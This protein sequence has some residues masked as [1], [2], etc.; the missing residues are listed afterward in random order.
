MRMRMHMQWVAGLH[1]ERIA[2]AA[3]LV[4]IEL[5][6]DV[7]T[8]RASHGAEPATAHDAVSSFEA[9]AIAFADVPEAHA[10]HL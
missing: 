9:H 5:D 1:F 3:D 10:A 8:G 6:P 4:P 7:R 2:R